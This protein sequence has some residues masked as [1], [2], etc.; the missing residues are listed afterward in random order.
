MSTVCSNFLLLEQKSK[1][2]IQVLALSWVTLFMTFVCIFSGRLHSVNSET[3]EDVSIGGPIG[4]YGHMFGVTLVQSQCPRNGK[5]KINL[6]KQD[7]S[8]IFNAGNY[9]SIAL[10]KIDQL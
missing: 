3:N 8:F 4:V 6:M 9:P 2:Y 10:R 1:G 5:F 7:N